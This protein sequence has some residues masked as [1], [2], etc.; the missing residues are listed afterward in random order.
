MAD[1]LLVDADDRRQ[2]VA[3]AAEHG[4]V[5][6][7]RAELEAVLDVVRDVA[8]ALRGV[9]HLRQAAEHDQVAVGLDIAG[10]AGVQPAV[11]ERLARRLVLLVVAVEDALRAHQ[12]LAAVAD[13]HLDAGERP[14]DRVQ[15]HLVRVL[16]R[17]E[18]AALGLAV[19]LAQLDAERAVE[20]EGVLA[21][22]LAAGEGIAHA[23]QAELV[24]DRAA[25]EQ[26]AER[27]QRALP[28]AR[29]AA[30][31]LAPLG[32]QRRSP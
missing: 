20:D 21:D 2:R 18:G 16:H 25:D 6:D 3:V 30:L 10:V 11:G 9:H 14:A 26:F 15:P 4:D 12:D 24:L 28:G 22:R 1:R 13:P 19:E 17:V 31:E 29:R 32:R 8:L 23:R 5:L 7:V 27:P